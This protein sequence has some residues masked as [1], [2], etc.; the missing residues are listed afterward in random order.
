MKKHIAIASVLLLILLILVSCKKEMPPAEE[1]PTVI[2]EGPGQQMAA[3]EPFIVKMTPEKTMEPSE[4]SIK[5]G[6]KVIWKNEDASPHNLM[7]Y[8]KTYELKEEDI[9]RSQNF[10]E[11]ESF[12][13]TF[14]EKGEYIVR[15]V[16]SGTMQAKVVV[17]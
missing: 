10:Y 12:E 15:C 16:Y 14:A 3:P 13:Y 17:E 11:N 2:E 4:I 5:Q 8:K 1:K 6:T 9:I 7:I